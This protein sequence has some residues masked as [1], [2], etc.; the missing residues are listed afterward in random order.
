MV[1]EAAR[2]ALSS[3]SHASTKGS[4][5]FMSGQ[6]KASPSAS[7]NAAWLSLAHGGGFII[8]LAELPI[9]ARALGP[10]GLGLV[11][12]VQA[13][14]LTIA[15]FIE[16]GFHYS[17]ARQVAN[18]EL[19]GRQLAPI[20]TAI[21]HAKIVLA[22]VTLVTLCV[23]LAIVPAARQFMEM[24]PWIALMAIALG[25]TPT[26]YF[27]GRSRLVFPTLFD[28]AIRSIGLLLIF[29]FIHEPEDAGLAVKIYVGIGLVN[30]FVPFAVMMAQT[31]LARITREIVIKEL[32]VGFDFFVYKGSAS[33]SASAAS[34]ILGVTTSP[35][36]VGIFGPSEK[37]VR[38]ANGL[39]VVV[40]SAFFPDFVRRL[41]ADAMDGRRAFE[42]FLLGLVVVT[43][44]G[45][46]VIALLAAPLVEIV[47]G[48]GFEDAKNLLRWMVFLVPLRSA[49]SA[50]TI[51]WVVPSGH[52]RYASRANL[53]ALGII[54]GAGFGLAPW[55]G[56]PGMGIAL[57]IGEGFLFI[58][59][60]FL[61]LRRQ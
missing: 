56:A 55:L 53:A 6:S 25:F 17:G 47:F 3:P 14:A 11:L 52:E 7:R 31:G 34:T 1:P 46:A 57:A 21:L 27:L 50:M 51:L 9:L 8:P 54:F 4:R 41:R 12:F 22:A 44:G 2:S 18:A 45:A 29:L 10:E 23:V 61:Y 5:L 28:L 39:V 33:A 48:P 36:E 43:G 26:W 38:A 13:A 19:D 42:R 24:A 40:L 37:L 15:V 58:S 60:L 49:S 35:R 16:Y 32:F 20:V 30:T 59:L